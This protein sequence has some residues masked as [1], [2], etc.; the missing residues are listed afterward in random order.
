[1]ARGSV[2]DSWLH[3]LVPALGFVLFLIYFIQIRNREFVAHLVAN[4]L[5]YDLEAR[6]ILDGLPRN[7]AFFMSPLYPAFVALVYFLG[8]GS[9]L[10]VL[11]VQ[12]GLLAVNIHLVRSIAGKLFSRWVAL[13]ASLAVTLYWS[14]YYFAGEL[15]PTTLCLTFFLTALLLFVEGPGNARRGVILPAVTGALLIVLTYSIPALTGLGLLLKGGSLPMPAGSYTGTIAFFLILLLGAAA[16]IVLTRL[17]VRLSR[18]GNVAASGF[19]IGVSMLIWSGTVLAAAVLVV[20]LLAK[21]QGRLVL[22]AVFA[23]GLIIPLIAGLTH[24]YMIS[25]EMVPLTTT[26]GVNLFIGNNAASDGM[27]PFRIGEA[28]RARIEADRLRLSGARRSAY[29]RD[30]ALGYI[31]GQ[32]SGWLKLCGRKFLVSL[33]R[34]E[35]DNNADISERRDAWKWFF[36]PVLNFGIVFPLA[37][38][39]LVPLFGRHRPGGVLLLCYLAFLAVGI[40]FFAS[41]RFRLPGIACLIPLAA[42]GVKCFMDD[43][44]RGGRRTPAVFAAILLGAALVSN[45][46]F[47][48]LADHEFASIEVNKAHVLRE[49]GNLDEARDIATAVVRS[50]PDEAGAYFQ[51]GAIEEALGNQGRAFG[52]FLDTLERDPFYY[53][54]YAGAGRILENLRIDKSYLDAYVDALIRD[55]EAV[56]PREKLTGFVESRSR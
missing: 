41:E 43:L 27:N 34:F 55:G 14:F 10:A 53:A 38:A 23:A 48:E 50:D 18:L 13:G 42:F 8:R 30:L 46:D 39:A 4:P 25:G 29:F 21:K 54:S 47:L 32:P 40:I 26:G 56:P 20:T 24:N 28:N 7:R 44:R 11:L 45:V 12:G 36:I 52:Y 3:Y 37:M 51:L 5:V 16:L 19:L 49:S 22:T 6:Q 17:P 15:L 31:T 1:M 33:S 35:I 2:K 9:R